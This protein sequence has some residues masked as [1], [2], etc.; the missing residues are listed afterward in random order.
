MHGRQTNV[1]YFC[2]LI[3]LVGLGAKEVAG[4]Q[5]MHCPLRHFQTSPLQAAA[6]TN[7]DPIAAI[8]PIEEVTTVN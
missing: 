1:I 5:D 7:F 8:K 6:G 3:E 2:L 4:R